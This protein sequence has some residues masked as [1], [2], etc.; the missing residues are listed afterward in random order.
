[1]IL[2]PQEEYLFKTALMKSGF[3]LL[4]KQDEDNWR[5]QLIEYK[6]RSDVSFVDFHLYAKK[7][8]ESDLKFSLTI[9]EMNRFL[10]G[11]R[12]E[13]LL[14]ERF[15]DTSQILSP[16]GQIIEDYI[17]S[18]FP[19]HPKFKEY[20][21]VEGR[22]ERKTPTEEATPQNE[23]LSDLFAALGNIPAIWWV[24]G[25]VGFL[26]MAPAMCSSGQKKDESLRHAEY[27]L[28]KAK[29]EQEQRYWD[30]R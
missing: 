22:K 30:A 20:Q 24:C 29:K 10:K 26:F 19:N 12:L 27:V 3:D 23:G 1:M 7:E 21:K 28:E 13:G 4:E 6:D 17:R 8:M 14:K 16:V 5:D 18:N 15:K 9:P 25:F 11:E 2:T